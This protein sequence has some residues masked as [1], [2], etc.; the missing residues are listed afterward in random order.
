MSASPAKLSAMQILGPQAGPRIRLWVY[1]TP[2]PSRSV[3]TAGRGPGVSPKVTK[4]K[5]DTE[6]PDPGSPPFQKN[7]GEPLPPPRGFLLQELSSGE[8]NLV[9]PGWVPRGPSSSYENVT[10]LH[11]PPK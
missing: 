5:G 8:R 9:A 3:P 7:R 11:V 10:L 1:T 2:P 4:V 6:D